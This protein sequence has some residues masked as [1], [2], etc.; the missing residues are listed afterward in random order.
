MENYDENIL[1]NS[2]IFFY[3]YY[4]TYFSTLIIMISKKNRERLLFYN[5]KI[6]YKIFLKFQFQRKSLLKNCYKN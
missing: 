6:K 5:I 4:K 2:Q 3:I 1:K